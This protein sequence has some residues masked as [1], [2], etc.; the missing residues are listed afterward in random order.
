MKTSVVIISHNEGQYISKCI[1]SVL[2]QIQKPDEVI[3]V[4]HNSNDNSL[5]VAQNFPVK[6]IPLNGESGPV[7]ARI[8][9]IKNAQGD[10]ILCIDGDSV[11]EKNW[12]EVMTKTLENNILVGSWVK[13]NGSIFDNL[14]NIWNKY[15]CV[16]KNKKAAR[17]IWG[18]SFAFWS[19]DKD[20]VLKTLEKSISTSKELNLPCEKIAEDF[21]LALFMSKIGNLEITNKT[22]VTADTKGASSINSYLRNRQNHKNGRLIEKFL[23]RN[24]L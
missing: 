17:W 4:I 19:K 5:G 1:E 12:V 21:W 8:E 14:S 23:I 11:A 2:N 22:W 6:V 7:Y 18:A 3:L 9:G 20:F 13:F 15:F 10:I 24:N 16:S